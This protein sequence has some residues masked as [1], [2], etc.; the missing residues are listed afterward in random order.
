VFVA[1]IIQHAMHIRHIVIC[2]LSRSTLFFHISIPH[3]GHDFTKR[4]TEHKMCVLVFS[5]TFV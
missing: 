3:K 5:T 2:G 4:N 1:L